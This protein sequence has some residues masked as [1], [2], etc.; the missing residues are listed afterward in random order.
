MVRAHLALLVLPLW[1]W[2]C[3][4]DAG[5]TGAGGSAGNAGM[6]GSGASGGSG[7]QGGDGGAPTMCTDEPAAGTSCILDVSGQ[8]VDE[9]QAAVGERLVTVCGAVAC[10]PGNSDTGGDFK[11]DV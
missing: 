6:G 10:N 8:I 7:G 11:V 1:L 5:S 4:D 9:A 3:G 2:G